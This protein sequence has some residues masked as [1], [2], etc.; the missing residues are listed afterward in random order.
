MIN[1][2]IILFLIVGTFV[3]IQFAKGYRPN[4]ENRSLS[5]TGLLSVSS[6]P[7]SARVIIND[8]LTT[9]T[10]DKLYLLP[11]T[12]TVK[13]EKDGFHPWV[14]TLPIKNELV[15]A[16]D[17]RL[18]PI[19]T[20]TSPLTFYQVKNS[21]L[22]TD[23]TKI[24][25]VLKDSPQE[26]TNGL[27]I[28][29]LSGNLLGSS[30]VQI[31]ENTPKDYS[32]ALLIWSPDSS[33]IL[34]VFTEKDLPAGRQVPATKNSKQTERISATYLLST[35]GMNSRV[36]SDVTLRLPLIISEWQDQFAKLN[37]PTLNLFPRYMIDLLTNNAVN[38]YFSPDKEKVFYTALLDTTL[39]ENEIAKTL[40]NIN[41]T[42]ETRNLIKNQTYL[43]DL[44]EGTN[45]LLPFA[46][47]SS[48]LT[49]ELIVSV[50]ATPSASLSI[51]RQ[52]K[53]QTESRLT[54]NLSWYSNSRQLIVTNQDGMSLTSFLWMASSPPPRMGVNSSC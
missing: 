30:N 38:V 54:T 27:Y 50:S 36:L 3:A 33:Q 16:S 13:I 21:A 7:K 44:K 22:N 12:Y 15:T 5:G 9:V 20:A 2:F 41:S 52:L 43:F 28:H 26:I 42:Q 29:S 18:F 6:Y 10:D 46:T 39:P 45:Y 53:A 4:L 48:E 34:A 11:G 14:K 1:L 32:Q 37:L 25:Y 23:G 51:I 47:K 40:P 35:K 31:A 24:A 8:K 19:I 49:K 17:A